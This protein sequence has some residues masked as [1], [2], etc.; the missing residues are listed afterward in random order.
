MATFSKMKYSKN[1]FV[2]IFKAKIRKGFVGDR[3]ERDSPSRMISFLIVSN[4][5]SFTFN[6]FD[7]FVNGLALFSFK[8]FRGEGV[9]CNMLFFLLLIAFCNV[10][11]VFNF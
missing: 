4:A 6:I 1:L 10:G 5:C 11:V 2:N 9:G 8:F 3:K 7:D